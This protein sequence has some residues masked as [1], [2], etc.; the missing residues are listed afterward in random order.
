MLALAK[1]KE[2]TGTALLAAR[3]PT[4]EVE[5]C[6]EAVAKAEIWS[7]RYTEHLYTIRLIYPAM[8]QADLYIRK[9]YGDLL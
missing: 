3:T 6:L 7:D 9:T 4:F 8:V 5:P 2:I 1:Q